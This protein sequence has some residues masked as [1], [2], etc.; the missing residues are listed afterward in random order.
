MKRR[1]TVIISNDTAMQR[2]SIAQRLAE[3]KNRAK[4]AKLGVTVVETSNGFDSM[5]EANQQDKI[6]TGR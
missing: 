2:E 6:M 4:K 3:R 5:I 1:A